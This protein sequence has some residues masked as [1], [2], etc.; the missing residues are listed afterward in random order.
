MLQ[1]PAVYCK[2]ALILQGRDFALNVTVGKTLF[3]LFFNEQV[4]K[5]T[6]I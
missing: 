3:Y 5:K 2:M 6:S 1:C 4:K